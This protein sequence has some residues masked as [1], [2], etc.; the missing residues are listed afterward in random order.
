MLVVALAT[1]FSCHARDDSYSKQGAEMMKALGEMKK[2]DRVDASFDTVDEWKKAQEW[3]AAERVK[4]EI[5]NPKKIAQALN[6]SEVAQVYQ[7]LVAAVCVAQQYSPC[8]YYSLEPMRNVNRLEQKLSELVPVEISDAVV[9]AAIEEG[10]LLVANDSENSL[11]IAQALGNSAV[12]KLY[13]Q[14]VD[15]VRDE[16]QFGI[17]DEYETVEFI[18]KKIEML[19]PIEV[20][21]L[22]IMKALDEGKWLV[23]E[24]RRRQ[25]RFSE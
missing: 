16:V 25:E 7:E 20:A 18:Q 2:S 8:G 23:A 13:K 24:D 14:L 22:V 19:L 15:A 10:R 17:S 5:E 4:A 12:V 11:K 21:E 6:N 1:M 9:L 3:A